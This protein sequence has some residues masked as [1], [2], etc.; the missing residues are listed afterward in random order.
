MKVLVEIVGAVVLVA[1]IAA[2]LKALST[3]GG[4]AMSGA[5]AIQ[6]TQVYTE[7]TF[8]AVVSVAAFVLAGVLL[9]AANGQGGE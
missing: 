2:L 8:Y 9:I 6:A 3:P 7:A 5:S 1:G 4:Y